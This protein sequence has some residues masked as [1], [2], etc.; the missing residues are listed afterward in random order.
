[1]KRNERR[2]KQRAVNRALQAAQMD[3][4]IRFSIN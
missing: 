3:E 1:V 4:I 2:A